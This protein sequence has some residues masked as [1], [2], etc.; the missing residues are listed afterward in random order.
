MDKLLYDQKALIEVSPVG[1]G[2]YQL[3][4]DDLTDKLSLSALQSN[5]AFCHALGI[6]S[7]EDPSHYTTHVGVQGGTHTEWRTLITAM[8]TNQSQ[9]AARFLVKKTGKWCRV[10]L[11]MQ[12]DKTLFVY[13]TDETESKKREDAVLQV[14]PDLTFIFNLQG[15][16]LEVF[17]LDS[18]RLLLPIQQLI[19]SNLRQNFPPDVAQGAIEAFQEAVASNQL[20]RYYYTLHVKVKPEHFEARIVPMGADQVLVVVRDVTAD[21][22][23]KK[24]LEFQAATLDQISDHVT[25]SDLHGQIHY[26]NETQCRT[27][28]IEKNIFPAK[29]MDVFSTGNIEDKVIAK[30]MEETMKHGYW[31]GEILNRDL[32]GNEI[33]LY[34]RNKMMK[35]ENEEVQYI[36]STLTNITDR[37][38]A[39]EALKTEKVRAEAASSAKSRFLA[40]MSH[41][42]R[43]PM[44]GMMGFIQLLQMTSLDEE[45]QEYIHF[46]DAAARTLLHVISDVLDITKIESEKVDVETAPFDLRKVVSEAVGMYSGKAAEKKLQLTVRVDDK[47]P[48]NVSGDEHKMMQVMTNLISNAVKFTEQGQVEIDVR[49]E[50]ET[51]G[52]F[53]VAIHVLDE[54]IGIDENVYQ[55]IFDPF[56]QADM[57]ISKRFGGTGLGLAIVKKLI[58]LMGGTISVSN[59]KGKGSHFQAIIP[60]IK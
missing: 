4:D 14:H 34:C 48:G 2:V 15:D 22:N 1:I 49:M 26:I 57:T 32:H 18:N 16:Y 36:I 50:R 19:G 47:I 28:G 45:Q 27:F 54:G 51:K 29:T 30:S 23:T 58:E 59:R 46:V 9:Q 41:E 12:D 42:I 37:K 40:N 55:E 39:E 3:M 31:E 8:L 25:V 38:K 6:K 52:L 56:V 60:F 21:L 5:P 11:V 44:N 53:W 10:Q 7:I 24:Q 17:T 43:T 35:V 13:L 20:V 33:T